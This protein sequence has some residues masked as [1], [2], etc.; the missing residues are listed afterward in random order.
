MSNLVT[1]G[2]GFL[3]HVLVE[4]LVARGEQVRVFCRSEPESLALDGVSWFQGDMQDANAVSES[5]QGIQTVYHCAGLAGI[6]GPWS[7]Y[8]SINVQGT[9]NLLK[10]AMNAGATRLVFTSSPS[11]VFDGSDMINADET[12]PLAQNFLC[13]YPYSKAI[14]ETDVLAANGSGGLATVALRPHL[15]WGPGDNHVLPRMIKRARKGQLRRVGD[16]SNVISTVYVE[17]AAAAHI[18]AADLLDLNAPH[19]GKVYFINEPESVKMWDWVNS[20]LDVAECPAVTKSISARKARILGAVL[21]VLW[22]TFRL[23]GE[24]PM[25]RFLAEQMSHSHSFSTAAAV[26]DFGYRRIVTVEEGL[27]RVARHLKE[28]GQIPATIDNVGNSHTS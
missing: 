14:A 16:G 7:L 26:R 19:A 1:G 12:I 6:W 17:N 9:R 28:T 20:L 15:I 13:G 18:Q 8:E 2:S 25:T 3:G 24:P 11:V 4:Q 22:R 21:E 10:S 27:Q 23:K 5:C